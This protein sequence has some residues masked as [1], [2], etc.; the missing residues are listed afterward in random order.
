M[1]MVIIKRD[2]QVLFFL[3]FFN[4][5]GNHGSADNILRL[6]FIPAGWSFTHSLNVVW[7]EN[8]ILV[9]TTWPFYD[10]VKK[11]NNGMWYRFLRLTVL[12][13]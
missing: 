13:N 1:Q 10:V 2:V 11:W 12:Q 5:R 6:I 8:E 3:C 4:K 7:E 9:L